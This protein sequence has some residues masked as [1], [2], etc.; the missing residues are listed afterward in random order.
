MFRPSALHQLESSISSQ[1]TPLAQFELGRAA[2]LVKV[3]QHELGYPIALSRALKRL[4]NNPSCPFTWELQQQIFEMVRDNPFCAISAATGAGKSTLIPLILGVHLSSDELRVNIFQSQP[5]RAAAELLRN[6]VARESGL[7]DDSLIG[8]RHRLLQ[9][10][11][12]E[13]RIMI[14]TDGLLL[15]YLE[16]G[17]F[18]QGNQSVLGSADTQGRS[19]TV[20]MF[21]EYHERRTQTDL[22][23]SLAIERLKQDPQLRV[24]LLSATMDLAAVQQRFSQL[25]RVDVPTLD[26]P[27]RRFPVVT[28]QLPAVVGAQPQ[29]LI[30]YEAVVRQVVK[31]SHAG[32]SGLVLVYGKSPMYS[33]ASSLSSALLAESLEVRIF[34][35]HAELPEQEIQ[36]AMEYQGQKVIL[37]TKVLQTSLTPQHTDYVIVTG[38]ERHGETNFIHVPAKGRRQ[39][40]DGS[41]P[42]HV[43][44]EDLLAIKPSTLFEIE[45]G[46]GR[47]G[48]TAP[49]KVYLADVI[50]NAAVLRR[51]VEPEIS[52]RRLETEVFNLRA[53]GKD[54]NSLALED[55]PH[56]DCVQHALG[57]G[58]ALGVYSGEDD[59]VSGFG[60]K[61]YD[62]A[63][64]LNLR[65]AALFGGLYIDAREG[66]LGD[67]PLVQAALRLG[68]ACAAILETRG[69]VDDDESHWHY[70]ADHRA[71]A[72]GKLSDSM[73]ASDLLAQAGLFLNL[74]NQ[75][76]TSSGRR[77]AYDGIRERPLLEASLTYER[78][79]NFLADQGLDL[80]DSRIPLSDLARRKVLEGIWASYIDQCFAVDQNCRI[81]G[82]DR[83]ARG[84]PA[85]SYVA[86]A[87]GSSQRLF[88]ML[89]GVPIAIE[90][91]RSWEQGSMQ[92]SAFAEH[93]LP[94]RSSVDISTTRRLIFATQAPRPEQLILF[95]RS[96]QARAYV[97]QYH[98]YFSTL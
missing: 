42:S 88:S 30:D 77:M 93:S 46:K 58:H 57:V 37:G 94:C 80:G 24:V 69:I 71:W 34:E 21:D 22:A 40:A 59:R 55:Y 36:R 20:L 85:N 60:R 70:L 79:M 50:S 81:R 39:N 82:P 48:R 75:D 83:A 16:D 47:V 14:L 23:L 84:L 6:Y 7:P 92:A 65:A 13:T 67:R 41:T 28:H 43:Y 98:R 76:A 2:S 63:L 89:V 62:L 90:N 49:G 56:P 9:R 44:A 64:P 52:R 53:A 31:S 8:V 5:R 78:M 61:L 96:E 91:E 12:Q 32:E 95:A 1:G 27:L 11:D 74:K 17:R 51:Q 86:K 54:I 3:E 45:Q 66:R 73:P 38:F 68:A 35:V 10:S 33:L 97:R 4:T 26:I 87:L 25:L 18:P 15:R 29:T 19:L 72:T